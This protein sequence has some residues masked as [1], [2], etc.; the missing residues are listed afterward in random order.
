MQRFQWF[1]PPRALVEFISRRKLHARNSLRRD[2]STAGFCL[3][4]KKMIRIPYIR[5]TAGEPL[6]AIPCPML[7]LR[8][9]D[10]SQK[11]KLM[12]SRIGAPQPAVTHLKPWNRGRAWRLTLAT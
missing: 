1:I 5:H 10:F 12:L 2:D 7:R 4:V 11:P 3:L 9:Q 8:W 6:P